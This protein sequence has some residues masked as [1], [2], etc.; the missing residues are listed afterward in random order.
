MSFKMDKFLLKEFECRKSGTE[1]YFCCPFCKDDKGW[2]YWF[3]VEKKYIHKT[4]GKEYTGLGRCWKCGKNHTV[5]SFVMEYK[6]LDLFAGLAY[7]EGEKNLTLGS[8]LKQ[9]HSLDNRSNRDNIDVLMKQYSDL[10]SFDLPPQSTK[11]LPK[12][13]VNWFVNTRSYPKELLSWLDIRYCQD[14]YKIWKYNQ[15]KINLRFLKNYALFPITTD[16]AK[17]WQAYLFK[18]GMI[19]ISTGDKVPKTRN[20]PGPV[21]HNLLFLYDHVKND[22]TIICHEGIFD[23]L[24]TFTR[25]FSP[26]GMMGKNLSHTQAF[27]LAKT[28]A[29]EICMGLDGGELEEIQTLKNCLLL[30]EFCDSEITFLKLPHGLDPDDCPEKTFI[31]CYKNRVHFNS[32]KVVY[33]GKGKPSR[34]NG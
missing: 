17:G 6:K 1:T 3:D 20:P 33:D 4:N 9:I 14:P 31:K 18:P 10:I 26:V 27:M 23:A 25:G 16:K 19:N 28:Q 2:N 22:H 5:L 11:D 24:R 13:L 15:N 12:D 30:E 29:K 34:Y 21:M 8:I 7:I 32:R